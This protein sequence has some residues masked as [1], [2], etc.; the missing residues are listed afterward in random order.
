M[1]EQAPPSPP[2]VDERVAEMM[3]A[4]ISEDDAFRMA[5][6]ESTRTDDGRYVREL[7]DAIELSAAVAAHNG[8]LP[9]PPTLPWW[10]P[11]R[12]PR[13]CGYVPPPPAWH[14]PE[15][16][17]AFC[18][19]TGWGTEVRGASPHRLRADEGRRGRISKP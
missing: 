11:A 13:E 17:R 1:E 5:L 7:E 16:S 2:L 4:G 14:Q 6:E 8:Q 19:A 9:P 18:A 10:A 12:A 3:P 15:Q